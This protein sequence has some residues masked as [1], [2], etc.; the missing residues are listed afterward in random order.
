MGED[1]KNTDQSGMSSEIFAPSFVVITETTPDGRSEPEFVIS[2]EATGKY[3][4]AN[5]ATVQ[6]FSALKETGQ[7]NAALL[8]AGISTEQGEQLIKGMLQTG[9]LVRAGQTMSS[10]PVKAPLE[11]K[12]ISIRWDMLD[13]RTLVDRFSVLGRMLFSSFGYFIWGLA[14]LVT[15]FELLTNR[16]K[17]WFS[18]QQVFEA[19]WTQWAILAML[20]IGLKVVHEMGHGLAYA[21][22]CRKEGLEPGPIRMGISTFAFT[23]FPFT[24]VTGAWRLRSKWR[25]MMIGAGGIYF[26]TWAIALL[27]L[28]WAQTGSGMLQTI[29]LQV[30]VIAG[31]LTLA[32]NLNP[33]VKL[34]GYF[35]LTDF[36]KQP[37]LA[38]RASHS[39]RNFAA[40]LLGAQ[41]PPPVLSEFAYWVL[42]YSYRWTIFAG[43]FWI[44]FQFD[45]RLA[46]V[47]LGIVALT[48][49][50]RPIVRTLSFAYKAGM[51]P[52]RASIATLFVAAAIGVSFV[53]FPDRILIPGQ[54]V[55]Y[56]SQFVE[57][58]E[59]GFLVPTEDK[60]GYVISAPQLDQQII[61]L[62]LR[63]Q[64]LQNLERASRNAPQ[65]KAQL[66][67]EIASF[68]KSTD[69]L[70]RRKDQLVVVAAEGQT[71]TDISATNLQG[72][73]ITS[74]GDE[75]LGAVS[76]TVE[77]FFR[78]R[79]DQRYLERGLIFDQETA[80][81]VRYTHAPDC[82]VS[83]TISTDVQDT[84]IQGDT[85]FF[86]AIPANGFADCDDD[87]QNGGA[88]VAKL[89]TKPRS[90]IERTRFGISRMLQNRLPIDTR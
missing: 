28:F 19:S 4:S 60:L 86:R 12:A 5:R 48:L 11:S 55:S 16:D 82:E 31:I 46:P 10:G 61:D 40:R 68:M 49:L 36:L 38:V 81:Q 44:A 76:T 54:L 72:A 67:S 26:E 80:L 14:V 25:R 78:L 30:A 6:F 23:P 87:L 70:L 90:L 33:A 63:T 59:S 50:I 35:I 20:Y 32:F 64:M 89:P 56:E 88:V 1:Q 34:D 3:F 47:A 58:T 75:M 45:K 18:L 51:K 69:E 77:P 13:S 2:N 79:L 83:A 24:D 21:T 29:I 52:L 57:A 41:A 8:R 74:T 53:P 73:W 71:W 27:T 39:A 85:L 43:I 84:Q 15:L 9:I 17:V 7:V 66:G 62:G 37:N 42:S 22:M 65:E